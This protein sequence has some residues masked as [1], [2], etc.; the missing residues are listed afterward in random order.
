MIASLHLE[1]YFRVNAV[2]R[3]FFRIYVGAEFLYFI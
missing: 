1:G 2:T 3:D